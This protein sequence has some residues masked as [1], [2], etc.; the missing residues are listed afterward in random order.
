MFCNLQEKGSISS[1]SGLGCS[2]RTSS[3]SGRPRMRS[4]SEER[5]SC[6]P[7][8]P[9]SFTGVGSAVSARSEPA[10]K[11]HFSN[12]AKYPNYGQDENS[13]LAGI[14][15]PP[16]SR[17]FSH[18][19]HYSGC[20]ARES[21]DQRKSQ[22]Q[23][24]KDREVDNF[25][26]AEVNASNK[27]HVSPLNSERLLPTRHRTKNAVLTILENGEVCIEF[28]KKKGSTVRFLNSHY[29]MI[30]DYIISGMELTLLLTLFDT[31]F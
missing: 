2:G 26:D 3:S 8:L 17:I 11:N 6:T 13:V 16:K 24:K 15:P 10:T 30:F 1:D 18:S 29:F 20:Q 28:L 4:R 9:I 21:E 23:K 22:R 27:L 25:G 14:P 5:T 7:V 12:H 19:D 31:F